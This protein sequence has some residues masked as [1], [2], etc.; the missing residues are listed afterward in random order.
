VVRWRRDLRGVPPPLRRSVPRSPSPAAPPRDSLELSLPLSL[1]SPSGRDDDEF[2][3]PRAPPPPP[4]PS[5]CCCRRPLSRSRSRSRSPLFDIRR[6]TTRE[7]DIINSR[8][9]NKQLPPARSRCEAQLFGLFSP[10]CSTLVFELFAAKSPVLGA[11]IARRGSGR[12]PTL[13]VRPH[14]RRRGIDNGR[15]LGLLFYCLLF[16]ES[17]LVY[18]DFNSTTHARR[19]KHIMIIP[20]P[21]ERLITCCCCALPAAPPRA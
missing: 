14:G 10:S 8:P 3:S 11:S 9:G 16:R 17:S 5:R 18:I 4:P 21:P 6:R 2:L 13:P 12:H 15:R 1:Y 7:D 19:R 20:H